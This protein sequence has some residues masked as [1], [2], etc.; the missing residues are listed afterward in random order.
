MKKS[1]FRSH[2][3]KWI[4]L[5]AGLLPKC[6]YSFTNSIRQYIMQEDDIQCPHIYIFL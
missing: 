1:R 5:F 4:N 2:D 3:L 6:I